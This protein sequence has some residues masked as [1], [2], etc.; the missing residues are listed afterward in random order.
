MTE[1]VR[2]LHEEHKVLNTDLSLWSWKVNFDKNAPFNYGKV[3]L[4][5]FSKA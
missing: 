1:A 3:V 5:D 4:F 2:Y